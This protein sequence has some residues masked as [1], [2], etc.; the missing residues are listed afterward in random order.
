M[1]CHNSHYKYV[2]LLI[3]YEVCSAGRYGFNCSEECSCAHD[4]TCN[5]VTGVCL[6]P[7]GWFGDHCIKGKANELPYL[8]YSWYFY[9][10]TYSSVKFGKTTLVVSC[11]I[12]AQCCI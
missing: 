7:A 9:I 3:F 10:I 11:L 1:I 6:C 5:S 12:Q 4:A 2:A 8:Y